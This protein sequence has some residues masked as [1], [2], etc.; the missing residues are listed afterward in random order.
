MDFHQ[1]HVCQA[2]VKSGGLTRAGDELRLSQSTLSQHIKLMEEELGR[3]L[4]MR[5]GK[6][7]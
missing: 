3:R 5:V 6:R 7:C 4:F 2:V 1:P